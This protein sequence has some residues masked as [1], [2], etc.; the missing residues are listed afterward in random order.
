ME[1]YVDGSAFRQMVIQAAYAIEARKKELND[2]NVFPVPDGDTGINMSATIN[3]AAREL[4]K[5]EGGTL[6]EVAETAAMCML[7]GARG[8][9][10]RHYIAVVSGFFQ[11]CQRPGE[12]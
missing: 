11:A 8:N 5:E 7:R 6:G 2:L 12:R 1:N 9:S 4:E 3:A 10:R